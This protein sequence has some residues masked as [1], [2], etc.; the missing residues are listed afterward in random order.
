MHA[1]HELVHMAQEVDVGALSTWPMAH[2]LWPM[3]FK[4]FA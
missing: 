3:A 1:L 4:A 2:G